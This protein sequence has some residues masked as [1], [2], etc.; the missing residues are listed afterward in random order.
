MTQQQE[1]QKKNIRPLFMLWHLPSC[2]FIWNTQFLIV[3]N[4]H[5]PITKFCFH[6]WPQH[7]PF[8]TGSIWAPGTI[9]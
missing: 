9:P 8:A 1:E 4:I 7:V 3:G 6:T 2:K 5:S